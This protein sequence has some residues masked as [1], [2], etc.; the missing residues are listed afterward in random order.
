VSTLDFITELFCRV[1]DKMQDVAKPKHSQARLHPSEVV[2]LALLFAIKGVGNRAFYRWVKRDYL[3]EFPRLPE[4]TRL[5]RL[6]AAHQEWVECFMAEPTILG[7]ADTYGVELL[8]IK[9]VGRSTKQ[10]G[11]KGLSNHLWIAGGKLGLV[12]NKWGLVSAWECATANV[13]DT[14]FQPMV[15]RFEET[16]VVLTD[17]GF[18]RQTRL[19]GDPSNMLVRKRGDWHTR[20]MV[21]TVLSMMHTVCHLKHMAHRVWRYFQAHLGYMMAAFNLL[22][23][24]NGLQPDHQGR[25]HLSIAQFSL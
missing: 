1:D 16:M 22:A 10:I 18:H 17:Y 15:A 5:F 6:F 12:L 7:V 13:H 2:A 3:R 21:E 25:V 11:K 20:M 19:G 4:R 14:F 8:H 23:Q 9:R 24:W